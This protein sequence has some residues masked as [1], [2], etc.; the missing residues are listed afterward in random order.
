[1]QIPRRTETTPKKRDSLLPALFAAG[2]FWVIY[3]LYLDDF[4]ATDLRL[5]SSVIAQ[6]LLSLLNIT[7]E[8]NGTVLF[9]EGL[10]FEVIAACSGSTILKT[11]LGASIFIGLSWRG[12]TLLRRFGAI[13]LSLIIAIVCNGLRVTILILL[14]LHKG[15]PVAEG[16]LHDLIG[17]ATF[18]CSFSLFCILCINLSRHTPQTAVKSSFWNRSLPPLLTALSLFLLY[19]PFI[20]DILNSWMGSSWDNSNRGAFIFFL[21][22]LFLTALQAR[23]FHL[24]AK[25]P[26]RY[27]VIILRIL[28]TSA[29]LLGVL[30]R[31]LSIQ[32]LSGL[33]IILLSTAALLRYS[34]LL[35]TFLSLPLLLLPVLSFPRIILRIK[36]LSPSALTIT[37]EQT[38]YLIFILVILLQQITRHLVYKNHTV[39]DSISPSTTERQSEKYPGRNS[40]FYGSILALVC[41]LLLPIGGKNTTVT[42]AINSRQVNL[43][44]FLAG[45]IGRDLPIAASDSSYFGQENIIFR[46]YR[47]SAN[48]QTAPIKL[49]LTFSGGDRHKNHPPEFCQS[50]IGWSIAARQTVTLDQAPPRQVNLLRLEQKQKVK[51]LVY[52]FTAGNTE[53]TNFSQLMLKD[54][55]RRLLSRP[56]NWGTIRIFSTD[57]AAALAFAGILPTEL[58]QTPKFAK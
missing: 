43:P 47:L 44:Y 54:L 27:A 26:E 36:D 35:N 15:S 18:V 57:N 9:H 20:I 5:I 12:L 56:T 51:Y 55:L 16:M 22:P 14:G 58:L 3:T 10:K 40:I 50:G 48:P 23:R 1:M 41:V 8:R 25:T 13:L 38:R 30:S 24:P 52:Y 17:I 6:N 39:A 49:L 2:L 29:L 46:E 31:F 4:L 42:S 21:L 11:M 53:E 32:V 28:L 34:N 45:W 7:V 33:G 37:P 19:L